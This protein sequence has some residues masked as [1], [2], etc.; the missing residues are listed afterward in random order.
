MICVLTLIASQLHCRCNLVDLMVEI[1][2]MLRP[3]GTV[4]VRDAPEVIDKVARIAYAVRWKPTIH[5]KEPES[6]GR[7]KILVMTKTF[8]KL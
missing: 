6:D 2:R 5:D 4:V 8:W 3:E 7:E 1:D